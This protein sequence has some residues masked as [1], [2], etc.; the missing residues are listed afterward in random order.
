MPSPP[1]ASG[2]GMGTWSLADG[3]LKRY[4]HFDSWL[5]AKEAVALATDSKRVAT[6]PFYPFM[7]Y[8]QRWT[9]FAEKGKKGK[10]KERPI[11]FAARGDAYIFA[12]YRDVLSKY[13]EAELKAKKLD[14]SVLAYRKIPVEDG[15]GGKCNIHF[16][17]DAFLKIQELG[18]CAVVAL[19]ISSF[20]E[21]L[22]SVSKVMKHA[23]FGARA[24]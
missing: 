14:N 20:F 24:A 3:R 23:L 11:R 15:K 17:R 9:R 5:S 6:H 1:L 21:H 7:R 13:Y 10:S 8:V 16:A 2:A 4:P 12:Y 19:D 22:E 18:D